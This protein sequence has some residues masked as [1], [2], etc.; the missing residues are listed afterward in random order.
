MY[1]ENFWDSKILTIRQ[2]R[3]LHPE[4]APKLHMIMRKMQAMQ[5]SHIKL[6]QEYEYRKVKSALEKAEKIKTEAENLFKTLS[7]FE[8]LA[9]L[10]K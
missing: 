5:I 1:N 3:K 6:I 2:W 10:S 4:H 8:L 7:K 9:S